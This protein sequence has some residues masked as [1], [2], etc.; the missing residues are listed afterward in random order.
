MKMLMVAESVSSKA[1]NLNQA[2]AGK[3]QESLFS[4]SCTGQCVD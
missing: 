1:I 4:V 3:D 2:Q